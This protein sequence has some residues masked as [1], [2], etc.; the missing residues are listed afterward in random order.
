MKEPKWKIIIPFLTVCIGLFVFVNSYI[1]R[2]VA[3]FLLIVTVHSFYIEVINY[4]KY[5]FDKVIEDQK[6][7]NKKNLIIYFNKKLKTYRSI[8]SAW[9]V[10]V[11]V[12]LVGL[13]YVENNYMPLLVKMFGSVLYVLFPFMFKMLIKDNLEVNRMLDKLM[14]GVKGK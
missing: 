13:F 2:S 9:F 6:E 7:D 1:I 4:C 3:M 5:S 14:T 12:A 11:T 8:L 10:L